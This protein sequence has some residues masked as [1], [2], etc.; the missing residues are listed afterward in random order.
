MVYYL[1]HFFAVAK[2][3]DTKTAKKLAKDLRQDLKRAKT[4]L[5]LDEEEEDR[6]LPELAGRDSLITKAV[7]LIFVEGSTL[8]VPDIN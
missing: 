7:S 8:S 3:G 4:S 1:L 6:G 2:G 5:G